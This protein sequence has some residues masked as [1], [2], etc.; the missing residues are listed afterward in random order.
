MVVSICSCKGHAW[1]V[2]WEVAAFTTL[3]GL[4]HIMKRN[5][6]ASTR[7]LSCAT[8]SGTVLEC[9]VAIEIIDVIT[10]LLMIG[11]DVYP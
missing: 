9:V 1:S 4:P 2:L 5:L 6:H 11:L 10:D 3:S 7:L 8:I